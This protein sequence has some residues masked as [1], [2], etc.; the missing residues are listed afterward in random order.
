MLRCFPFR[1]TGMTVVIA[2]L[3]LA[4]RIAGA[5]E[6]LRVD[7]AT[8]KEHDTVSIS[9]GRYTI[10]VAS[11]VPRFNYKIDA[12]Q[13]PIPIP[14][15]TT[16]PRNA[17]AGKECSALN[18]VITAFNVAQR[19]EDIPGLV[20]QAA[21]AQAAA[22]CDPNAPEV[23]ELERRVDATEAGGTEVVNVQ[24]DQYLIVTVSRTDP[25]STATRQWV[26]VFTT[27]SGGGWRV[28][29]GYAF[30]MLTGVAKRGVFAD[31][32]EFY[33]KAVPNTTNQ[34]AIT[35]EAKRK[36]FDAVP[37]ILYSFTGGEERG[38]HWNPLTAG[39]GV[40][41]TNPFVTLGTG[42]TYNANLHVTVGIAARRED[43]LLGRYQPGD[44]VATNLAGTQLVESDFR[45]HPLIAVTFRFDSSPFSNAKTPATVTPK[46]TDANTGGTTGTGKNTSGG[47]PP[48]PPASGTPGSAG[49]GRD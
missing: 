38:L 9:P 33:T 44:I 24:A 27:P 11:Q 2:A 37:T 4:T 8:A 32:Q 22:A 29:Y 42:V 41:L 40:D 5:Q 3:V 45:L 43:V 39:L 49:R 16:V 12:F 48:T 1:Q 30:P 18:A 21:A 23:L 34:F 20:T 35:A 31:A 13:Q 10:R 6:F 17:P 47:T 28:T 46:T 19:E 7:L 14:P 36:Q 15:L 25:N 26:R